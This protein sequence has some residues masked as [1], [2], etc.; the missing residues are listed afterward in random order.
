VKHLKA[1]A[2]KHKALIAVFLSMG[3]FWTFL[4]NY[5]PFYFQRVVDNFTDGTLTAINIVVYSTVLFASSIMGYLYNYPERK[6]DN[7]IVQG[8]KL[9]A[10]RKMSVIDYLTYTKLGTGAL[11]QRIE[12]GASAGRYILNN[13]YLRI[14]R[15]LLPSMIFSIVFVF[16]IN[17][18]IMT[19]LVGC[20]II[21]YLASNLLLKALYKV[22]EGI[23]VNEEKFNHFLV[24]GFMELVVFRT[25]RRFAREIA[26]TEAASKEIISSSV[27]MLMVH[28]AFFN[29]CGLFVFFIKIGIIIYGWTTGELTI[30]Q[31]V[32][33]LVLVEKTYEPIA[34]F[35]VVNVYN[36][37]EK[38]AFARYTEFL[39]AKEDAGS[40]KEK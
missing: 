40:L 25:N 37:L 15:D 16:A 31:I 23:L 22:K 24:R 33:L 5:A 7:S 18:T 4:Q 35:N 20:Y 39:D 11:I 26:K 34:V 14:A 12:N 1:V 10:L 8:L 32:A 36:K 29:I 3:I 30:G 9:A 2:R 21:M 28:E 38:I 17:R 19:A 27:K 13:Y 6:L